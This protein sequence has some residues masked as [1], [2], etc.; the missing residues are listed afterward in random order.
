ME[1]SIDCH[2]SNLVNN[3]FYELTDLETNTSNIIKINCEKLSKNGELSF[4]T[5]H[6]VWKGYVASDSDN[7]KAKN[8][9]NILE[10]YVKNKNQKIDCST[11]DEIVQKVSYY[12]KIA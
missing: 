9:N 11:F 3:I 5:S 4:L 6:Q 7:L 1:N 2:V 12:I 10:Y 8:P